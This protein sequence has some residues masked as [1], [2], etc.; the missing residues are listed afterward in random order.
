MIY[1]QYNY[2]PGEMVTEE[3]IKN[4]KYTI[5]QHGIIK[6]NNKIDVELIINIFKN[7]KIKNGYNYSKGGL[8]VKF[9]YNKYL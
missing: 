2:K 8:D 7:F 4:F 3:E 5:E 6:I 9:N 1:I